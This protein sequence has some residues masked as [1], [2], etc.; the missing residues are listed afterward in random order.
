MKPIIINLDNTPKQRWNIAKQYSQ[1][2]NEL[3][4]YYLKDFEDYAGM[5]ALY[6]DAYKQ[7]FISD[8]YWQEIEGISQFCDFD[9]NQVLLAN[10]YYDLVKYAFACTAFAYEQNGSIWHARNLD[11][12]TENEMLSKYT[13]VF[14]F[15]KN[16][17]SLFQTVGW[18]GF[19]GALSGMKPNHFSITLNAIVSEEAPNFGKPI[20]FIIRDVLENVHDFKTAQQVLEQETLICDCLL[21][22]A[23]TNANELKVIERTPTNFK[24]RHANNGFIAVTNDYKT[25]IDSD[26]GNLS[27]L[28]DTSCN[29][30]DT[31]CELLNRHLPNDAAECFEYLN[32]PKV[33]MNITVQQMVFNAKL[34]KVEVR[35]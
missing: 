16:G 10:L 22:L 31:T 1:S 3:I 28:H 17:K 8:S 5:I 26:G 13:Q 34:G 12:W 27:S 24:T 23:G 6:I 4:D 29:R 19:I 21:L 25:A 20:S 9:S 33:K 11:W 7:G 30:F 14:D 15:Y 32:H 2:M 18:F 35:K